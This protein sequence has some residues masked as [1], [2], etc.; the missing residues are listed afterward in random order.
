VERVMPECR[1]EWTVFLT[2]DEKKALQEIRRW[3]EKSGKA[4]PCYRFLTLPL[5]TKLRE[6]SPTVLHSIV[7]IIRELLKTLRDYSAKTI[8]RESLFRKIIRKSNRA[9]CS[10]A[11]VKEVPLMALDRAARECIR[12]NIAAAVAEGGFSGLAGLNAFLLDIPLLYGFT[13][14]LIQ[15][16]AICYGFSI[17]APEEKVH[18]LKVLELGHLVD[19]ESRKTAMTEL[20]T[21]QAAIKS[22]ISIN[23]KAVV[24]ATEAV[25][26]TV[27][28]LFIKNKAALALMLLGGVVGAGLNF[29]IIM[30]VAETAYFSYRKRFLME[31][32]ASVEALIS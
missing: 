30:G 29:L 5:A 17:E 9:V 31:K 14:R 32:A 25:A 23:Q 18:M 19:E 26:M 1:D 27:S 21:L 28:G 13:F 16:V 8:T 11:D 2:D 22:G 7:E 15:E 20:A 4:F 3:E 6:F 24:T 12:F 10:S